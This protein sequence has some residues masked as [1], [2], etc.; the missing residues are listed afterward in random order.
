MKSILI[1]SQKGGSGKSTVAKTLAVLS[2]EKYKTAL[3][4]FDPQGSSLKWGEERKEELENNKLDTFFVSLSS[5]DEKLNEL[6]Q[7]GY[8]RLFID[9]PPYVSDLHRIVLEKADFA[10]VPIQITQEDIVTL[11]NTVEMIE[12]KNIPF[13]IVANRV[14][15]QTNMFK[16]G[17]EHILEFGAVF[18]SIAETTQMQYCSFDNLV[19]TEVNSG[20]SKS[21]AHNKETFKKILKLTE[22]KIEKRTNGKLKG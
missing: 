6:K 17:L 8:E 1:L 10:L 20:S 16:A 22:Q 14:K 18:G 4:D 5:L 11:P 9:T 15:L 21:V 3:L 2:S 13:A 7:N 12:E 19:I